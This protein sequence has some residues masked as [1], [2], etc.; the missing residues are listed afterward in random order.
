MNEIN[1]T[2]GKSFIEIFDKFGD[3]LSE[4]FND[5][6]LKE[7]ARQFGKS[8]ANSVNRFSERFKDQEVKTKFRDVGKAAEEFG[9]SVADYFKPNKPKAD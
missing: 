5:P 6:E 3:A 1:K 8:A 2:P 9:H 7:Q 4:I